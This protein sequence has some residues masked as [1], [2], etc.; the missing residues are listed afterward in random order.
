MKSMFNELP[1]PP[2]EFSVASVL[3]RFI[4]AIGFRFFLATKG[5]KDTEFD[6]RPVEGS[7]NMLELLDHMH[8]VLRW[9]Y[10]ACGGLS[11]NAHPSIGPEYVTSFLDLCM[12]FKEVVS[13]MND[14]QLQAI[15]IYL[16]RT[17]SQYSLWYL[18]NGPLA[19]VMT[20]IGQINS[21]R[22][23]AGNPIDSISPFTGEPF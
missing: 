9:A 2:I 8:K 12:D 13:R 14:E 20:H 4:D 17:D 22:R 19:D 21:W 10:K 1:S 18:I 3:V 15:T 11:E 5:L 6:F 7:M 16:K 23:M